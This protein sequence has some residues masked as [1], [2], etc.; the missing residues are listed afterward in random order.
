MSAVVNAV[1]ITAFPLPITITVALSIFPL[2]LPVPLPVSVSG[3]AVPLLLR[4]AT[5]AKQL[6]TD[7]H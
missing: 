7:D 5:A 2:A 4:P 1:L 6:S 3:F